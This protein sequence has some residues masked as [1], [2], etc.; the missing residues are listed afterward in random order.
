VRQLRSFIRRSSYLLFG[1]ILLQY[2]IDIAYK[3]SIDDLYFIGGAL[4][5]IIGALSGLCY[6]ACSS[7]TQ[8]EVKRI[9]SNVGHRFLHCF[10]TL[11]F[12]LVFAGAAIATDK[13]GIFGLHDNVI[14]TIA[15]LVLS[16]FALIS[17]YWAGL[18]FIYAISQLRV[19]LDERYPLTKDER[20][21]DDLSK[22]DL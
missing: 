1:V 17:L 9:F 15:I 16:L 3:K 13:S 18:S 5:A 8:K 4:L 2:V 12:G 6:S 21:Y 11:F 10:T 7:S 20:L 14:S 22:Q 19:L